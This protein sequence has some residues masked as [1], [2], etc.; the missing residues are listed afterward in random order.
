[1]TTARLHHYVPQSYLSAFT[2]NGN[3]EGQFFVLDA[4][5]GNSFRTSPKN[6]AKE[7]DF[8]RVDIE[9]QPLD[10]AEQAFA[11]FEEPAVEAIRKVLVSQVFPNN[12]DCN[13]ILNLLCLIAIRNPRLRNNFNR[14]REEEIHLIGTLLVSD[15][16]LFDWHLRRARKDG[17]VPDTD[18][19]FEDVKKFVKDRRYRIEFPPGDNLRTELKAFDKVLPLLGQRTWSLLVAPAVGPE[20]ICSD[21]PVTI[22]WKDGRCAPVGYGLKETEVFFSLGRRVG[23]YGTFEDP[24][25][26]IVHLNP[27]HV[28]TMNTRVVMNAN[29]HIF[30]TLRSFFISYR[31][32]VAE[33]FCNSKNSFKQ[34][35]AI[36]SKA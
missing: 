35:A 15:K 7:R 24:L 17:H 28:A 29:K 20:F 36:R 27:A 26:S 8:N 14:A 11:L 30:S 19:S 13:L 4:K 22:V 33:L 18:V 5:T 25:P 1:M 6:V 31:G 16:K 10:A 21:H 9:G 34:N 12:E 2:D 3:K 23:F 32:G